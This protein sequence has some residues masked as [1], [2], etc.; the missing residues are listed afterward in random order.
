[1]QRLAGDLPPTGPVIS[2]RPSRLPWILG[3][4]A[5]AVLLTLVAVVLFVGSDGEDN[6]TADVATESA[7]DADDEIQRGGLDPVDTTVVATESSEGVDA[8]TASDTEG[9]G[10][11]QGEP[12]E[13]EPEA[14]DLLVDGAEPAISDLGAAIGVDTALVEIVVY[15]TYAITEYQNPDEPANV[16][17]VI[18]RDGT[19]SDPEPVGFSED[20]SDV[21]FMVDEVDL[22]ALPAL[23]Q[24]AIEGFDIE[25]GVVTHAIIDRF[26]GMDGELAVRVYVSHPERG[27]GG[28][29]LARA[30]GTV[31]EL[32]G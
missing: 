32:V 30:D 3:A 29:L 25:G 12:S 9:L 23:A 14:V 16:D 24:E 13:Q 19:V 2:E 31:V 1:V 21:L 20:Y 27:G 7:F 15:D 22:S 11:P 5:A 4:I 8:T 18:W 17:R 26:F 10:D 28:Y 6:K